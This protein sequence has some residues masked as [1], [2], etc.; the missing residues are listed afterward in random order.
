M[1]SIK[2]RR[3]GET[4]SRSCSCKKRTKPAAEK[5]SFDN[6]KIRSQPYP[7]HTEKKN[8]ADFDKADE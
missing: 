3:T 4:A 1:R 8:A 7:D 2:R 5:N 6:Q